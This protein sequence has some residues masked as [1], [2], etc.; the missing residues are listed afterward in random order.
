MSEEKKKRFSKYFGGEYMKY[1]YIAFAI[2]VILMT[3][4]YIM[5]K[6]IDTFVYTEYNEDGSIA[7]EYTISQEETELRARSSHSRSIVPEKPF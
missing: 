4:N 1:W 2:I 5:E 3:I 6:S 7:K